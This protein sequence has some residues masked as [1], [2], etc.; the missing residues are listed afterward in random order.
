[1]LPF[2]SV[3]LDV[4][5]LLFPLSDFRLPYFPSALLPEEEFGHH[6]DNFRPQDA[7]VEPDELE[8][9]EYR[10]STPDISGG[11]LP[12]RHT[13]EVEQGIAEGR[14]KEG[15]LHVDRK[16]HPEPNRIKTEFPDNRAEEGNSQ[17]DDPHPVDEAT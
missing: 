11:D 3:L 4:H 14:R 17:H 12:R 6:Q 13:L 2:S 16:K 7:K 5:C 10:G 15:H 9:E 1:M 8:Q